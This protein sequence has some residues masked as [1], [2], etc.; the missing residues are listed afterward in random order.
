MSRKNRSYIALSASLDDVFNYVISVAYDGCISLINRDG[1]EALLCFRDKQLY[2]AAYVGHVGE[3]AI[4]AM[5]AQAWRFCFSSDIPD[6][7]SGLSLD[8]KSFCAIEVAGG[9]ESPVPGNAEP[10]EAELATEQVDEPDSEQVVPESAEV[11]IPQESGQQVASAAD[12]TE[13]S[14]QPGGIAPGFDRASSSDITEQQLLELQT[15]FTGHFSK[16]DDVIYA[17]LILDDMRLDT[18]G[19]N[20]TRLP[21]ADLIAAWGD[22]IEDCVVLMERAANGAGTE[23]SRNAV[24][25]AIITGNDERVIVM[26]ISDPGYH[27]GAIMPANV[28]PAF[29]IA[30][31]DDFVGKTRNL[32]G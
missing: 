32:F 31:M 25:Q 30:D 4:A 6:S 24:K 28:S 15:R 11:A 18:L 12:D 16:D 3:T 10:A 29:M 14:E 20:H 13:T 19:G 17:T 1:E 5:K 22:W 8:Y 26:Y 27:V 2:S 23:D 7:G 9:P 21:D